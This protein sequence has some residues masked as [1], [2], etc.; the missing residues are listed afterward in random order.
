MHFN[1]M[2]VVEPKVDE[3]KN[4]FAA[5]GEAFDQAPDAAGRRAAVE[6]WDALRKRLSTWGALVHLQFAQDTR[7]AERKKRREYADSIRP[8]LQ[9]FDVDLMKKLLAS[10]HRGELEADFGKHAFALWE[11]EISTFDPVIEQ[12]L[13]D[14]ANLDA[15]YTELLSGAEL[16]FRGEKLNLPGIT[17]YFEDSDRATRHDAYQTY[18]NWFGAQSEQLD[19]IYDDMVKLRHSMAQKLGYPDFVEL[20]YRRMCR[21]DYNRKDVERFRDQ[22]REIVVPLC[23]KI[24]DRQ[25][26]RIGVDKLMVWDEPVHDPAGNPRPKGDH[27][28]MVERATEM[29]NEMGS[30]LDEFWAVMRDRGLIDLKTREG[31][32]GGGF[33][34]SFPE[35]GVPFIYANFNGTK[36]DVEVFTH[37]MGHAFQN[38]KSR[39]L[40]PIDYH[41]PTSETCEIHSM[42]LE[43]LTYPHM[44][45]FFSS[46]AERFRDVH[47]TGSLTFLPYGVAVDHFQH[48]VY[49]NPTATP[50]ERNGMWRE[51]EQMYLPW[52]DYG[53]LAYPATGAFWQRQLHIYGSPFYYIDYTLAQVCALQFWTRSLN[54]M[55]EAMDA[56]V[57]LC[58]RGGEAAFQTLARSA[59]LHSPF[60]DGA[61]DEVAQKSAATLGL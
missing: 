47:L 1:D 45:K 4:E 50:A 42:S 24:K 23:E 13:V 25:T 14:E 5:I 20:G 3:I 43:F 15:E 7:D 34:T 2:M 41:W 26:E 52:R 55:G 8:K 35:H 38:W 10:E 30:G 18:W 19:R 60:E 21:I 22:V 58:E 53:D 54:D 28:W 9:E 46:D 31:K 61:L 6:T 49:E 37:E 44:E 29:F 36:G 17:K 16:E 59:G 57:K 40:K 33:C 27:D 32:A 12:D 39:G 11:T 56:Y 48:L 51:V